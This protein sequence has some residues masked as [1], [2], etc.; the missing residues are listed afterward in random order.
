MAI[1]HIPL[2][3]GI[4]VVLV[5]VWG[6]SFGIYSKWQNVIDITNNSIREEWQSFTFF[7]AGIGLTVVSYG[8]VLSHSNTRGDTQTTA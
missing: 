2:I 7:I 5:G 8:Q 3:V 4:V 1:W 6:I